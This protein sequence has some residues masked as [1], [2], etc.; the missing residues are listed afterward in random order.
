[1]KAAATA[2]ITTV[3]TTTGTAMA[4][5]RANDIYRLA[6]WLSPAFPVGAYTYSGGLEFAIEEGLVRDAASL[7]AWLAGIFRH[8]GASIDGGFFCIA[9]RTAATADWDA[10][11]EA[12]DLANALRPT[13][14]LALE[15][16]RILQYGLALGRPADM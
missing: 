10:L 8:G 5:G 7:E 1:M 13:A 16:L 3:I 4:D 11:G 14:E 15:R 9:H 6:A 12:L 2:T